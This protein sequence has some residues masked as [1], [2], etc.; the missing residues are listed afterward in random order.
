MACWPD[1]AVGQGNTHYLAWD[2]DFGAAGAVAGGIHSKDGKGSFRWIQESLGAQPCTAMT[3][4]LSTR[5]W[6]NAADPAQDA[7]VAALEA[8]DQPVVHI[9]VAD[10]YQLGEEMFRGRSPP[11]VAGR[12]LGLTPLTSRRE[13]SRSLPQ[14]DVGV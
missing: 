11:Q 9:R 12:S 7:A 13:A 5:V 14:A 8:A 3:G 10:P 4:C 6:R 2:L 1:M